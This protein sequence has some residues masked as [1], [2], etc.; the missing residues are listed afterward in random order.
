MLS[1]KLQIHEFEERIEP[2]IHELP[3]ESITLSGPESSSSASTSNISPWTSKLRSYQDT[4]ESTNKGKGKEKMV[5]DD[6]LWIEKP[7]TEE[8]EDTTTQ[9]RRSTRVRH[10]IQRLTYD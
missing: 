10:P 2:E 9:S 7:S 6:Q 3:Q 1:I 4:Q 8:G 5:D